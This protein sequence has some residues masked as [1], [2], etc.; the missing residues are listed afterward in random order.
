MKLR[1]ITDS[2]SNK[3]EAVD[4]KEAGQ[5]AKKRKGGKFELG[6]TDK[7]DKRFFGNSKFKYNNKTWQIYPDNR[8]QAYVAVATA[9]GKRHAAPVRLGGLFSSRS[10][11]EMVIIK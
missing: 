11:D 5:L 1:E 4:F 9:S 2:Y 7:N 8:I 10:F 6:F 3:Y